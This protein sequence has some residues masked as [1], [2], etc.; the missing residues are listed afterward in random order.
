[1][2]GHAPDHRPGTARAVPRESSRKTQKIILDAALREFSQKGYDGARVDQIATLTGLNKNVLYH[3]FAS[4]DRLFAAV[5]ERTYTAIRKNHN[6][7]MLRGM[8]PV[9]AVRKLVISVGRIWLHF[10]E[11]QQMI[12][13]ENQLEGRHIKKSDAMS[14]KYDPLLDSLRELLQRGVNED[15]FRKGIDA[16]DLYISI[17]ALTAHYINNRYTLE[18]IFHVDLMSPKRVR[19]RLKHAA[20]MV[21]RYIVK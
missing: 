5:L 16:V 8:D 18:T 6:E 9:A 2:R 10:P 17:S 19:Q 11:F 14:H 4:K 15:L 13:C 20:D 1:V 7:I 3:H 12:R 21:L